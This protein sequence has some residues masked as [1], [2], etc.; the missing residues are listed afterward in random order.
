M[1]SRMLIRVVSVAG[2]LL[3]FLLYLW[4]DLLVI[5]SMHYFIIKKNQMKEIRGIKSPGKLKDED[6]DSRLESEAVKN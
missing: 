3:I 5:A 2:R 4:M 6:L 1:P